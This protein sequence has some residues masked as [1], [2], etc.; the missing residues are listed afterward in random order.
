MI[1][2][3]KLKILSGQDHGQGKLRLIWRSTSLLKTFWN[4]SLRHNTCF[5]FLKS[6]PSPLPSAL[7]WLL[8]GAWSSWPTFIPDSWRGDSLSVRQ[9]LTP[10]HCMRMLKEHASPPK[11]EF[12]ELALNN[13]LHLPPTPWPEIGT[14]KNLVQYHP[15]PWFLFH[16]HTY[17]LFD[18]DLFTKITLPIFHRVPCCEENRAE[19]DGRYDQVGLDPGTAGRITHFIAYYF[20]GISGCKFC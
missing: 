4:C 10:C 18:Q 11:N 5:K 14:N 17:Y 13:F 3:V 2:I 19:R 6:T 20:F 1:A 9:L 16:Y 12:S 15:P 8:T 7:M